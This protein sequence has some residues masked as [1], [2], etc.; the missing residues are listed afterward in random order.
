MARALIVGCGCRGRELGRRLASSGWQ[1]RGTTRDAAR[2]D[3]IRE[4]G[5]EPVVAD[6]DRAASVLDRVA[7]VTLVFWLLGSA[8]GEPEVVAAIHGPRLERVLEKLVD[9][10]VR[11]FVYERAGRVQAHHLERGAEIVREAAG[12][13]RIPVEIVDADPADWRL[14]T[15]AMLAAAARLTRGARG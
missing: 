12:R 15:D 5:L 9:T 13:W 3:E 8:L 11:G 7:E 2:T 1:V 10:P 6:P 14:W 4:A